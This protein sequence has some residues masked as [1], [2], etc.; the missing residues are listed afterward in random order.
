MAATR[1]IQVGGRAVVVRELTF[2]E[3]RDWLTAAESGATEDVLFAL[4]FDDCSLSDIAYMSDAEA[5]QLVG[6]APSELADLTKACKELNPHFFRVRT[7]LSGAV[8]FVEM[9]QLDQNS[10]TS[11]PARSSG[12]D[13]PGSGRI[14]G[15]PS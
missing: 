9:Q 6:Y 4:A 10:S 3:V 7:A 12:M 14:P 13:T 2:Q 15:A 1:V 8:R 11:S 5:A